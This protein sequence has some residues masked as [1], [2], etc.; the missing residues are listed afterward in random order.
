MD[1]VKDIGSILGY[2]MTALG[3]YALIRTKF[4]GLL[5]G[6]VKQEAKV[7]K[8]DQALSKLGHRLDALESRLSSYMA[9]ELEYKKGISEHI[10]HQNDACR[11]LLAEIIESTYRFRLGEKKLDP[12]ERRKVTR[13]YEIY[14]NDL[15]GNSYITEIYNEMMSWEHVD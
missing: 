2:I 1:T 11:Q 10:Q 12:V 14:H 6:Y 4:L 3:L 5:G 15:H 9:A 13:S 8:Y 7:D